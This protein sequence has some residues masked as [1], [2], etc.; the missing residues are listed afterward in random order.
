MLP[1]VFLYNQKIGFG[2]RHDVKWDAPWD[3]IRAID[4]D[5]AR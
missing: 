3:Y 4:A 2:V 1:W 5:V